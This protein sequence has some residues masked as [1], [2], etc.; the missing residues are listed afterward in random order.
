MLLR[1][2]S[3]LY[4]YTLTLRIG[5]SQEVEILVEWFD[6]FCAFA[7][8]RSVLRLWLVLA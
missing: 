2:L 4:A 7:L 6:L 5:D 3:L 8:H 1:E